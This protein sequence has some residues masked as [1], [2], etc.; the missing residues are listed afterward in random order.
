MAKQII[1]IG[2]APNDGTGDTAR[3]AFDICNDNFT[4]LY[5]GSA[6]AEGTAILSTGEEGGVKFLREDG[7]GTSSWQAIPAPEGT[8]VLSTGPVTDGYVLTADGAGG[9]AW[10]AATGGGNVSNTG[11]P[12]ND[13]IA[14]WTAATTVEGSANLTYSATQFKAG[15]YV[16]NTD[17]TV[18][19]GQDNYVPLS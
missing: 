19:A 11:T 2:S 14:V 3:D 16:L 6:V 18:G 12:L 13:Q 1:N 17:Q 15:N 10:E 7:D 8:S 5:S 4:E 9:A